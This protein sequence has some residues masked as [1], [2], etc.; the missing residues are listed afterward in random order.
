MAKVMLKVLLDNRV[1]SGEKTKS[2]ILSLLRA[3]G[4]SPEE[5]GAIYDPAGG[6]MISVQ[7]SVDDAAGTNAHNVIK[8]QPGVSYV[9]K[10]I[11]ASAFMFQLTKIAMAT[12][13]L[14]GQQ[15]IEISA[16]AHEDWN[17]PQVDLG[18]Y[19]VLNG[20]KAGSKN[21]TGNQLML[22]KVTNGAGDGVLTVPAGDITLTIDGGTLQL[23]NQAAINIPAPAA[24]TKELVYYIA[25]DGKLYYK[26]FCASD[27]SRDNRK[28]AEAVD[29]GAV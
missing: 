25:A 22:L 20:W 14:G 19:D 21:T 27:G 8:A 23:D 16:A 7:I 2:D 5:S 17:S 6:G 12:L 9:S 24:G 10:P 15:K 1:Q 4:H 11:P 13:T 18:S 26:G 3:Q 28:L 29:L